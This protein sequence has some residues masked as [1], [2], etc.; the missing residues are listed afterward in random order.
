MQVKLLV[1]G[2]IE[3]K[4]IIPRLLITL[5]ENAFFHGQFNDPNKPIDISL[6]SD[7]TKIIF[8]INFRRINKR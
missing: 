4:Y 7:K 6:M 1:K 5:V 3:N 2:E 8:E